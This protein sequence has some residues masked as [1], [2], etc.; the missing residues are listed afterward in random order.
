MEPKQHGLLF[1]VLDVVLNIV[2]IVAVVVAIRTFLVSPFQ[3]DGSSMESTLQDGEYIVINKL[4][5]HL[6]TPQRGDVAVLRPPTNEKKHYVKRVIGIPG[7]TVSIHDGFVYITKEGETTE[8]QL[9]EPYLNNLNY[10]H[11]YRHPQQEQS[12]DRVEY[13]VPEGMY[14]V[15]G[16]N[17]QNSSDSRSFASRG[18]ESAFVPE[19]N[20][21][22]RV[23]LIALPISKIQALE[24]PKYGEL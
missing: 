21:Q 10:G 3:V 18:S 12:D 16:D 17:R 4:A 5:Y 23:W 11:T 24:A 19:E 7:D 13:V 1:H 9:D 15:L 22:G 14:F 6:G 20:I 8:A 2:I